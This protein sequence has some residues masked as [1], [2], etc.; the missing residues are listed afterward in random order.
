MRRVT[1]RDGWQLDNSGA[2]RTVSHR[3]ISDV[4]KTMFGFLRFGWLI[5][6]KI[7]KCK[8]DVKGFKFISILVEENLKLFDRPSRGLVESSSHNAL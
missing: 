8:L 7:D 6:D 1:D 3:R 5:D 2:V 4:V